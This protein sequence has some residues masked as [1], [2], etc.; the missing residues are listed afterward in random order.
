MPDP[1]TALLDADFWLA[2]AGQP[3][4]VLLSPAA[5]AAFNARCYDLID[6]PPVLA[7][8]DTLEAGTM[9]DL[10]GRMAPPAAPRYNGAG[11][12][13]SAAYFEALV[14]NASPP[15]DDPVAVRF[16]LAIRRTDVR[17]FPTADVSTSAP[18]EFALDRFQ[19][20]TIDV[21]WPVAALAT[22]RDGR[23]LFCLTPH[24]WGWVRA[25]HI[26]FGTRETVAGFAQ[27]EPFGVVTA[28]R[29]LV[30]FGAGGGV[31]PQM[32]TR[33]PLVEA[34]ERAFRVSVPARAEGGAL[35]LADGF[36][37]RDTGELA[38]GYLPCTLRTLLTQ[39]F[40]LL[41][42]PYAWGGSR[43]GMFGRDCSRF[44]R[45]VVAVTGVILPRNGVQQAATCTP[46][47]TF[48]P[49]MSPSERK[50]L[51]VEG[52][53]P[54]AILHLPGHVM[55]YLGHVDGEPYAIHSTFSHG[56]SQVVVSDLAPGAGTPAGSLLERLTQAVTFSDRIHPKDEAR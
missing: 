29:A 7:L 22:S 42:E 21:G 12:P 9:R 30:A 33:L 51:L 54:G 40:K 2:R 25:E 11:Q 4:A 37:A 20:T 17:T 24:Y 41:G 14:D 35:A 50:A 13:V 8:P 27:A 49:G 10:I 47:A 53:P 36:V 32:G 15:L 16:G 52:A 1:P 44:I 45:D 6:I 18:F 55:L 46:C 3:D 19:E 34:S 26:A 28:S 43:L 48:A 39:A 31:T 56:W 5:V 38:A 23:W